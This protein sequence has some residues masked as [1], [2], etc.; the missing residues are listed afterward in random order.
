MPEGNLYA[1]FLTAD[2]NLDFDRILRIAQFCVD[3]NRRQLAE[4]SE[5][6]EALVE[7]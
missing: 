3:W 2:Q 6:L 1:Q 4:A 7:C 5:E